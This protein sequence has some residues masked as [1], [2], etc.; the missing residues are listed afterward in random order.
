V[1]PYAGVD[2]RAARTAWLLHSA[3]GQT[4]E[5]NAAAVQTRALAGERAGTP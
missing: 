3:L 5:A 4:A 1:K 2:Y